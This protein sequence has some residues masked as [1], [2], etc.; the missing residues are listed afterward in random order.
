MRLTFRLNEEYD[1]DIINHIKTQRN[2][3]RAI[4][5]LLRVGYQ[6]ASDKATDTTPEKQKDQPKKLVW[7]L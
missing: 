5:T 3:S 2:I 7:K 4:R 1:Q 6:A